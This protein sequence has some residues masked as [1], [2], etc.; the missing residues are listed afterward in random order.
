MPIVPVYQITVHSALM[1]LGL[2]K[3]GLLYFAEW[4]RK[5]DI[6]CPAV[7][8]Q[9]RAEHGLK[10][11]AFFNGRCESFSSPKGA[12]NTVDPFG[13]FNLQQWR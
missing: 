8:S 4:N 11:V 3:L 7:N 13:L 6:Q 9:P 12:L 5:K 2:L 10:S 1:E